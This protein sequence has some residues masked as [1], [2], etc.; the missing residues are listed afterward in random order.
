MIKLTPEQRAARRETARR[1]Y[2]AHRELVCERQKAI[3][4]RKRPAYLK[5]KI[6]E[7]KAELKSL[8]KT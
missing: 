4:D 8:T 7:L 6:A 5:Q 2:Y 3:R 1:W